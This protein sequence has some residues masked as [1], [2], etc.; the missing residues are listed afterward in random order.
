[1]VKYA[2]N[3][4]VRDFKMQ[5]FILVGS[6]Q[7]NPWVELFQAKMNFHVERDPETWEL[8]VRNKQPKPGE[9]ATYGPSRPSGAAHSVVALLPN[10]TQTGNVLII[11]GTTMEGTEAGGEFLSDP[12][13]LP[14]AL[15]QLGLGGEEQPQ[16]FEILLKSRAIGGTSKDTEPIAYR[17]ID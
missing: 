12:T 9:L 17:R 3:M 13:L 16:Y 10:L 5:N 4:N 11:E 6:A 15:A 8:V 7:S 2:R 1:M 14:H